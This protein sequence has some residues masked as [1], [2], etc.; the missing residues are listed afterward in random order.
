MSGSWFELQVQVQITRFCCCRNTVMAFPTSHQIVPT[1]SSLGVC[2]HRVGARLILSTFVYDK[3]PG[4][5]RHSWPDSC[6][7]NLSICLI[8]AQK[9]IELLAII[10]GRICCRKSARCTLK[11]FMISAQ[12]R[13]L[14]V[15]GSRHDHRPSCAKRRNR[16]FW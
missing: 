7:H 13:Y 1:L 5:Y 3:H 10:H 8:S 6:T 2:A 11:I 15:F 4:F 12:W 14:L 9:S 16:R